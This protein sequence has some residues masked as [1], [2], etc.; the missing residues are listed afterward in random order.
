MGSFILLQVY[1][2]EAADYDDEPC[3]DVR[4]GTKTRALTGPSSMST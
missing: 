2:P 3:L 4:V 1:P